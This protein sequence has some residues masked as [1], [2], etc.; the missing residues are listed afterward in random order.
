MQSMDN[1]DGS[2]PLFADYEGDGRALA[3]PDLLGP[4]GKRARLVRLLPDVLE[5][6]TGASLIPEHA[7]NLNL[8]TATRSGSAR[9]AGDE[10]GPVTLQVSFRTKVEANEA[11]TFFGKVESDEGSYVSMTMRDGT[12]EINVASA[13]GLFEVVSWDR[14]ARAF[15][16][17]QLNEAML[18]GCGV[19][20]S[21][22]LEPEADPDAEEEEGDGATAEDTVLS[23]LVCYTKDV[24]E[25]LKSEEAVKIRISD[26][27]NRANHLFINSDL[28]ARLKL[29]HSVE[30]TDY[31]EATGEKPF[32]IMLEDL[33]AGTATGL[34]ALH[35]LRNT[36]KA[37]LVC[38]L[39]KDGSLGGLA[40]VMTSASSGWAKWAYSVVNYAVSSSTWTMGHEIAHNLGCGHQDGNSKGP[41]YARGHSFKGSDQKLYKTVMVEKSQPGE[42][43]PYL[44]SPAVKYLGSA[45]GVTNKQ[46][47]A[48][49]VAD[50]W[51]TT[52]NF[53]KG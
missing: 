46:D 17:R 7:V 22:D 15:I 16:V 2:P 43:I 48:K 21:S 28:D 29:V 20:S 24:R 36:H 35:E 53:R 33:V 52:A 26:A 47:N 41:D 27:L 9:I 3:G 18:P 10:A 11:V 13:E 4:W 12:L 31:K 37:D 45:T 23:V 30:L 25:A 6:L 44:S 19:D 49:V 1:S 32:S 51:K 38:L 50:N 42:R 34:K 14:E 8:F 5:T 39:V 40:Y